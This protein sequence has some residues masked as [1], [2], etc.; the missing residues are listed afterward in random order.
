MWDRWVV[1][2]RRRA[3]RFEGWCT[4]H[5]VFPTLCVVEH[6]ISKG[7]VPN[8]MRVRRWWQAYEALKVAANID[9][10]AAAKGRPRRPLQLAGLHMEDGDGLATVLR[11]G[12]WF[13]SD[14]AGEGVLEGAEGLDAK[15]KAKFEVRDVEVEGFAGY[16]YGKMRDKNARDCARVRDALGWMDVQEWYRKARVGRESSS[17]KGSWALDCKGP[18]VERGEWSLED[19][20]EC[21]VVL[22]EKWTDEAK[23]WAERRQSGVVDVGAGADA[24]GGKGKMWNRRDGNA[25]LRQLFWA[26][27]AH[28]LTKEAS[29]TPDQMDAA[30]LQCVPLVKHMSGDDLCQSVLIE[31]GEGGVG[32]TWVANGVTRPLAREMGGPGGERG[33]CHSNAAARVLGADATTCHMGIAASREQKLDRSSLLG[34]PAGTKRHRDRVAKLEPEWQNV[35]GLTLDEVGAMGADLVHSV[36]LC[37]SVGREKMHNLDMATYEE[38]PFG[39]NPQVTLQGDYYQLPPVMTQGLA[40]SVLETETENGPQT[41]EVKKA[42]D[43]YTA[44]QNVLIFRESKRFECELIKALL[45]AMRT[46]QTIP[47]HVWAEFED[48]FVVA[49]DKRLQEEGFRSQDCLYAARDWNSVAREQLRATRA[50]AAERGEMLHYVFSVDRA[51]HGLTSDE[52]RTAWQHANSTETGRLSPIV[53]FYIGMRVRLMAKLARH[54][55][56]V[57]DATGTVVGFNW[58][59]NE[60]EVQDDEHLRGWRRCTYLPQAVWVEF[61]DFV[62]KCSKCKHRWGKCKEGCPGGTCKEGTVFVPGFPNGVV[63]VSAK[64]SYTSQIYLSPGEKRSFTRGQ[65]PLAHASKLTST[66]V[67]GATFDWAIVN[68]AAPEDMRKESTRADWWQHVYVMLSRVR[69]LNRLLVLNV[70]MDFRELLES[71]PPEY[72]LEEMARLE[73]LEVATRERAAAARRWLDWPSRTTDWVVEPGCSAAEVLGRERAWCAPDAGAAAAKKKGTRVKTKSGEGSKTGPKRLHGTGA[74]KVVSGG[75][76]PPRQVVPRRGKVYLWDYLRTAPTVRLAAELRL[77]GWEVGGMQA[78]EQR[79][80]EC[81]YIAAKMMADMLTRKRA[82]EREEAWRCLQSAWSEVELSNALLFEQGQAVRDEGEVAKYL[83]INQVGALLAEEIGA[84]GYLEA[85][86]RVLFV[87]KMNEFAE[88]LVAKDAPLVQQDGRWGDAQQ[89]RGGRGGCGM[90]ITAQRFEDSHYVAFYVEADPA[91]A[92]RVV[93]EDESESKRA[94]MDEEEARPKKRTYLQTGMSAYCVVRGADSGAE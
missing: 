29:L 78:R 27:R 62:S 93:E 59:E 39:G 51:K 63:P 91:G 18:P 66:G 31:L 52:A 13:D 68:V 86:N 82:L 50:E 2:C 20:K 36:S 65:M 8:V 16:K 28:E 15:V 67:Q 49:G 84:E 11:S 21:L 5:Q 30:A 10:V 22:N 57:N 37:A 1:T 6:L 34:G 75:A 80:V 79:S 48:R 88:W 44:I 69:R 32:K 61:D 45:G 23:E 7:K 64:E 83:E 42:W 72:V 4:Y 17:G 19:A 58:H 71:G 35:L 60:G 24:D 25:E 76:V 77:A 73:V 33:L 47:E 74:K 26:E 43:I 14:N 41:Y 38:R 56:L 3:K 92:K 12:G 89:Q 55:D 81:G 87:G 85:L 54:R 70:P 9:A 94:R 53:G 90:L 46:R 40:H